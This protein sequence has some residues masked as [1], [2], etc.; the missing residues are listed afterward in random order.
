MILNVFSEVKN[1]NN[2]DEMMTFYKWWKIY[3]IN[4]SLI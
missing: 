1:E 4:L 2:K 3:V